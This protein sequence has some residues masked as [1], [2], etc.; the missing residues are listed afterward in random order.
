VTG[1][2]WG[3]I[4]AGV[5]S[6]VATVCGFILAFRRDTTTKAEA[7]TERERLELDNRRRWYRVVTREVL[8]PVRD[9]FARKG[10]A[11]PVDFDRW[12]AYPPPEDDR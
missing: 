5:G 2:D 6:I 3:V 8:V 12:T 7:L 4:V 10:E 1:G 9:Y 11:E